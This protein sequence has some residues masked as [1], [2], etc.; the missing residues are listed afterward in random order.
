M[1]SGR[2]RAEAKRRARRLAALRAGWDTAAKHPA[3]AWLAESARLE[4]ADE[5]APDVFATVDTRGVITAN[6]RAEAEPAE[7]AWMFVHLLL[8]L[9]LGHLDQRRLTESDALLPGDLVDPAYA[10]ACCVVVNR[11]AEVARVGRAPFLM[12]ELPGGEED[13]LIERWRR[14]GVPAHYRGCGTGGSR[15]CLTVAPRS[16]WRPDR[17]TGNT[18]TWRDLFARG[19]ADAAHGA[20]EQAAESRGQAVRGRRM[21]AWDRALGWFVSSFPLLGAVAARLTLVDDPEIAR[22]WDITIAA[23]SPE[24]GEIYVNP[25]VDLTEQEWRFVLAHEMLHAALRHDLRA[26]G[27]DPYLWNVAC[28]YV[29]NGWLVEMAVGHLP[30]GT[31]YDQRLAALSA[32]SV[33]DTLCTDLRRSRKLATLGGRAVGD[34]LGDWLSRPDAARRRGSRRADRPPPPWERTGQVSSVD[35]DEFYRRALVAGLEYHRRAD[36]GLIAAG[37]EQEIKALEHP[38]LPWD[39][40]LARWFDEHIRAPES[41]RSYARASRRQSAT[42]DI[43]RPGRL[44]PEELTRQPTFG[45]VLD[46]SGS[47]NSTVLGKALGAI[48][49][50]AMARDVPAARIVCCDAVAYDAGYLPVGA[51]AGRVTVR[52]RGGTVLQPGVTLL[53]RAADFPADGPILI[54][55]DAACDIVRVRREHAFLIP[56]GARLPFTPRGPVF[57]IR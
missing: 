44:R 29:I 57:R 40:R 54:I 55:T 49:S 23:V 15:P 27:R 43:P 31:L 4:H 50:Y 56:A 32:E 47:M 52:G 53:E 24:H 7:W 33:Y 2:A 5:F 16:C 37:L 51:I 34:V 19:L 6:P 22:A 35:L 25:H 8:H 13:E 38:P 26:K 45:V 20:I 48:A 28:D 30:E 14:E 42:P 39:A 21:R 36:R 18:R 41:R 10:A 17:T 9:G 11:F 1:N 12:P 46:T 3:L